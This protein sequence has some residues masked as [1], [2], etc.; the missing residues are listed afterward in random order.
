MKSAVEK[1][2][3]FLTDFLLPKTNDDGIIVE[4]SGLQKE[5]ELAFVSEMISRSLPTT[6]GSGAVLAGAGASGGALLVEGEAIV[7]V[8]ANGAVVAGV[9]V[10][11]TATVYV[12]SVQYA[13]YTAS[14]NIVKDELLL[15]ASKAKFAGTDKILNKMDDVSGYVAKNGKLPDNF[16][17]KADAKKLGWNPKA[18]N[19]ADVAPG[20]S[21]GGDIFRNKE[22]LLPKIDGR[23]WYEAD[24]NYTS[25]FRGSN[26]LLYSSDGL[27]YKTTDHYKTFTQIKQEAENANSN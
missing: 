6:S 24:I 27:I 26:R 21:I 12:A 7:A 9:A 22:G 8:A 15:K 18:G 3:E 11:V 14:Q 23:V 17:T 10:A 5:V 13:G 20:K 19:L 4:L 16:I 1:S 2:K 25:G